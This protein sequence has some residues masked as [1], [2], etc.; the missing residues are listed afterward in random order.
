MFSITPID[1]EV[2]LLGHRRGALR[3]RCA[4]GCGVVTTITSAR[5]R[6]CEIDS[7]TSPVPGGMSMMR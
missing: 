5:G 7:D 3:D 4:A 6:N 1:V 2:D